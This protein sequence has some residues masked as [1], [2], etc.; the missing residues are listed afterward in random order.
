M[1]LLLIFCFSFLAFSGIYA[2]TAPQT[3]IAD[4]VYIFV[5]QPP[6]FDGDLNA[7]LSKNIKYPKKALKK[8]IQGAIYVSFIV[9]RDG[10]V[11][12]AK[13]IRSI[14]K[15]K[16]L[17]KEALRVVTHMPKWKPGMQGGKPVRVQYTLPVRFRIE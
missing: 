8:N 6:V 2:Q 13:I 5:E 9:E 7:Y 15:G 14:D 4:Q 3:A 16:S 10:S 11:S 17:E 12:S 1:K